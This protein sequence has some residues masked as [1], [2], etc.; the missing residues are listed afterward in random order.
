MIPTSTGSASTIGLII[1]ELNGK[2]D[3]I[4]IRVPMVGASLLDCVFEMQRPTTR[5]EVN[6]IFQH[7]S[8]QPAWTHIIGYDDVQLVS[9]DFRSDTRSAVIDA[10]STMVTAQTQVKIMAWYDNEMGYAHRYVELLDYVM[11]QEHTTHG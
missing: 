9:T 1:P 6:A 10:S 2:L 3:G 4:A 7:A 5:D 11:Q 8:T